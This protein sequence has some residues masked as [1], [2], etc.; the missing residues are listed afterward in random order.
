MRIVLC[1]EG[2]FP[3]LNGVVTFVDM[4]AKECTRQG[5]QVLI[6]TS[7][8]TARKNYI[9]DGVLRCP[10]KKSD[11]FLID[12]SVPLDYTRYAL[13]R[14]FKPDVIHI[15]AEWGISLFGLQT[16]KLL[17]IPVVYTLHTEYSKFLSYAVRSS[18][19]PLAAAI[20]ARLERY[21]AK[22]ATIITSPS[23]KGQSYFR[24]IGVDVEVEVI[25]NSVDLADFDPSLFSSEDKQNL[26]NSLGIK[27]DEMCA[28]FVGRMGPEKSVDVLL[29]YWARTIRPEHKLRLLL[30]GGGP[31]DK[32]LREQ[33]IALGLDNQVVFCGKIP[34]A[35]IGLYYAI[36]DTYVTASISE[37]HSVAM[38]EGLGSGLPVLQRL[39]EMNI[40]Q[41]QEGV[42][43]YLYDTAEDFGRL[44][45]ALRAKSTAELH[46]I[47]HRVRQ[48]VLHTNNP[49]ALA[50]KYLVQYHKAIDKYLG[51]RS[52]IFDEYA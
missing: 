46:E 23:R 24:S 49:K 1:T 4:L 51:E 31:D 43:G 5:H 28:L 38:L 50:D 41:L 12:L 40:G 44:L 13:V 32:K 34:H 8:H 6:V 25:Q 35:S 18:M 33:S 36:C 15:Q 48:S 21:I 27:A 26:R 22:R 10:A 30:I 29:D 17:R 9:K 7:D 47:R 16:A 3:I 14:A 39:D 37:M 42:N 19:I 2:Y 52:V 45:L 20:L 11:Q